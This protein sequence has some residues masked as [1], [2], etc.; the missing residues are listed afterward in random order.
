MAKKRRTAKQRAA[1]I[2]N[3]VQARKRRRR[4]KAT[5]TLVSNKVGNIRLNTRP[6]AVSNM[7]ES[8]NKRQAKRLGVYTVKSVSTGHDHRVGYKKYRKANRQDR[9]YEWRRKVN[10]LALRS[11]RQKFTT[12]AFGKREAARFKRNSSAL[13]MSTKT[14]SGTYYWRMHEPTKKQRAKAIRWDE[15]RKRVRRRVGI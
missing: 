12:P 5:K 11:K 15:R 1:S 9:M 6:G 13:I 7:R 3:L 8:P 10:H 2:R 14:D 4:S